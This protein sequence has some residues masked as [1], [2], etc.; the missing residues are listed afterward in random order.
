[1]QISHNEYVINITGVLLAGG[2][3]LRM[4]HDKARIEIGGQP[5]LSRSL[6]LLCR[7][8]TTVLIAGDRPD[9]ARPGIP[10]IPDIYPGSAL[11]GLYTGLQSAQTEWIFVAPCDMP[12]PDPKILELLLK[13]RDGADAVVPRTPHGYEPV[14]ALYHKNCLPHMEAMLQQGQYRIYDFYQRIKVNY[15]DWQ[16]MPAGWERSLLNIN[17]PEQLEQLQK[18]L[19]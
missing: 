8:F 11:G 5:L 18:E 6:D 4:G 16:Q 2:K 9:V 13:Q 3:S 10:A 7:Y 17:T 19:T 15:L 1:M 14:F 12:Y